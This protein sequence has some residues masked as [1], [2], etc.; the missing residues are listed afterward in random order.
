MVQKMA[1][2]SSSLLFN[3]LLTNKI[4]LSSSSS[5]PL[6]L[7]QLGSTRGALRLQKKENYERVDYRRSC[8]GTGISSSVVCKAVPVQLQTEIEGLNI[9]ED[10]TQVSQV[11]I[12]IFS[13]KWVC[14]DMFQN[15]GFFLA[16]IVGVRKF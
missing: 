7:G 11:F 13:G 8:T 5:E 10:V 2:A 1:A 9:A 16:I 14:F 3:P 6:K 15:V 12:F 4:S